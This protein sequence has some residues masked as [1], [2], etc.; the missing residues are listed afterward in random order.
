MAEAFGVG[1]GVVGCIGLAIQIGQVVV[2]FG[3]DWKDAPHEAKSFLAELDALKTVLSET[4]T[5]ILLSP[6]FA[7]AFQGRSSTLLA[8]LQNDNPDDSTSRMVAICHEDLKTL[9]EELKKK[10]ASRSLGWERLKGVFLG[11][12]TRS[13]IT[14]LHRKCQLLNSFLSI[15]AM[16]LRVATHNDVKE[17]RKDQQAAHEAL[18]DIEGR[19]AKLEVGQKT[20][21]NT[22]TDIRN[23]AREA[24]EEQTLIDGSIKDGIDEM[25]ERQAEKGNAELRTAILNWIS[26]RDYSSHQRDFI[27]RREKGTGSWF[28]SSPEVLHWIETAGSALFSPGIPGAGKTICTAILIDHIC[29]KFDHDETVGI[30]YI[31]CVVDQQGEEWIVDLLSSLIKQLVPAKGIIKQSLQTLHSTYSSGRTSP[32]VEEVLTVLQDLIADYQRV[33]ILVDALDECSNSNSCQ[34]KLAAELCNFGKT[35]KTSVFVTSRFIPEITTFFEGWPKLEIRAQE[36]DVNIY[37]EAQMSRLPK[38]VR[39]SEVL[40]DEVRSKITGV[41]DG[42]FLLGQLH[43]QSLIGKKS[44]KSLKEAL[45]GLPTGSTAYD[46]TYTIAMR[47]IQG[48]PTD[49]K[50]QAMHALSWLVAAKRTLTTEELRHA[51]AIEVGESQLDEDNLPDIEDVISV[52]AGLIRVDVESNQVQLVHFTTHEYFRRT[53]MEWFPDIHHTIS[54]SCLTYLLFD[55]FLCSFE[56]LYGYNISPRLKK[57][58]MYEYA[59]MNWAMH[60]YDTSQAPDIEDLSIRFLENQ[61]CIDASLA[62]I[63]T[64][65]GLQSVGNLLLGLNGS[66]LHLAAFWGLGKA[67][68]NL[69]QRGHAANAKNRHGVAPLSCAA[70]RNRAEVVK[71][72]L[73]E[74]EVEPSPAL[75]SAVEAGHLGIVRCLVTDPR[76]NVNYRNCDGVTALELAARM[77]FVSAVEILLGHKDIDVNSRGALRPTALWTAAYEGH[78]GVTELL[79]SAKG[80]D[81]NSMDHRRST[82]LFAAV[83]MGRTLI[84]KQLLAA[85]GVDPTLEDDSGQTPLSKAE[86][87]N[88]GEVVKVLLPAIERF[89]NQERN[90]PDKHEPE[91]NGVSILGQWMPQSSDF[92]S[93]PQ[94]LWKINERPLRD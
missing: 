9:L 56:E 43:L 65:E 33:F 15:D 66:A 63:W 26:K 50:E 29:R 72:L 87:G 19:M 31:Y 2:Q 11:N 91:K 7:E 64:K 85:D 78:L 89:Q 27:N 22:G 38:F 47:R 75:L 92:P 39:H 62:V 54:S 4:N 40:K 81:S 12:R 36:E 55:E 86:A 58:P 61:S 69:L 46:E 35:P 88:H 16:T 80:I 25:I 59:S 60:V 34:I 1:A 41:V 18:R 8:H 94:R 84:V 49:S 67:V 93:T 23:E 68:V 57:Y 48:Q 32:S 71:I 74:P 20:T 52:C 76:L 21:I 77:G 37:L 83:E 82:P 73:K 51:L 13:S 14:D 10:A 24:R 45:N 90:K 79:L 42:M 44:P 30:A 70:A 28:L 3:L 17:V 53:M 6:G 5:N